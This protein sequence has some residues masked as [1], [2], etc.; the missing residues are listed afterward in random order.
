MFFLENP[1]T[2][3]IDFHFTL[4]LLYFISFNFNECTSIS[5]FKNLIYTWY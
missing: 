3:Y 1:L 4:W 5:I 2:F